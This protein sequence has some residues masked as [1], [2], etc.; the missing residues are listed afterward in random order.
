[1]LSEN[2]EMTVSWK[3]LRNY[4]TFQRTLRIFK[5][6]LLRTSKNVLRAKIS[7]KEESLGSQNELD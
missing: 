7:L 6:S 5:E 4:C 3:I 1:M 2:T